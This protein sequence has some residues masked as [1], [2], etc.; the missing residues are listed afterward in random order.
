MV[1]FTNEQV[2]EI[3]TRI[4]TEREKQG[5]TKTQFY[6][7]SGVSSSSFSQWNTGERKPSMSSVQKIA[8]CLGVSIDYLVNGETVDMDEDSMEIREY[9]RQQPE[10]RIL[11]HASKGVPASEVLKVAAQLMK[12]KED[13]ETK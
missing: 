1:E 6:K 7:E 13:A 9:L 2:R 5:K 8:S 4:E 12:F 3:L 11:F 10:I